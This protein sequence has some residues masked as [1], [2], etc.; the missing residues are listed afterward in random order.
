MRNRLWSLRQHG[1]RTHAVNLSDFHPD[2]IALQ[3]PAEFIKEDVLQLAQGEPHFVT[4]EP[5]AGGTGT[6][7]LV[8]PH[9]GR[10]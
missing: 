7:F 9:L 2:R 10:T 4:A 3:R 8:Q 1:T 5:Y 6:R